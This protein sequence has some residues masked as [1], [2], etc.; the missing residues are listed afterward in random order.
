MMLRK[1]NAIAQITKGANNTTVDEKERNHK[2]S[3]KL[4]KIAYLMA[5]KM[6][7]VKENFQDLVKLI[8]QEIGDDEIQKHL[9]KSRKNAT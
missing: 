9:N 8:N 7:V 3:I 5:R 2:V 1:V 6:W 4:F